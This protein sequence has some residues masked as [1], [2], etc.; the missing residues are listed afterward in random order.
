MFG[1]PASFVMKQKYYAKSQCQVVFLFSVFSNFK[2]KMKNA[3]YSKQLSTDTTRFTVSLQKDSF[4]WQELA[5][6]RKVQ[7]V[8]SEVYDCLVKGV[9]PGIVMNTEL[10]MK[11]Y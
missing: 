7:K 3:T 8:S 1:L 10:S 9:A 5:M 6:V 4:H 2:I 11:L